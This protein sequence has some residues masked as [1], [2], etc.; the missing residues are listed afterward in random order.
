MI[1]Q[2]IFQSSSF[3][4]SFCGFSEEYS[5]NIFSIGS[6][7]F[8][9]S[10]IGAILYFKNKQKLFLWSYNEHC[11]YVTIPSH[12]WF[13]RKRIFLKIQQIRKNTLPSSHV[14]L[15]NEIKSYNVFKTTQETFLSIFN[16]SN[17]LREKKF[18]YSNGL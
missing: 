8:R 16:Y 14:K 11:Y 7:F 6:F 10:V 13:L 2:G 5:F 1:I 18:E 4:K 17:G 15:V 12:P 3:Q 9:I